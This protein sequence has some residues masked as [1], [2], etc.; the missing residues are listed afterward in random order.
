MSGIDALTR[1][2]LTVCLSGAR[3]TS[4]VDQ[5]LRAIPPAVVYVHSTRYGGAIVSV[6]PES[7]FVKRPSAPP[8]MLMLLTV[9]VNVES[10]TNDCRRPTNIEF[11]ENS[12]MRSFSCCT[13]TLELMLFGTITSRYE[14]SDGSHVSRYRRPTTMFDVAVRNT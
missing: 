2:T 4:N 10:I 9:W 7:V 6:L 13:D 14:P 3:H 12:R 5:C 11:E 8:K 1:S